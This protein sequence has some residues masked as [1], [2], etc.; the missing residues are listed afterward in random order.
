MPA[1]AAPLTR[2]KTKFD[3]V[4]RRS[5]AGLGLFANAPIPKGARIIEYTGRT[6]APGEDLKSR[7]KYLFAISEKKTIDGAPRD[8]LARYINHSC[9]PNCEPM[10]SRGRVF[11]HAKRAIKPGEELAYD[12]GPD[13]FTNYIEPHGCRCAKCKGARKSAGAN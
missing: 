5:A 9:R 8:N 12:Y 2:S 4:V 11:I 3:V 1:K 7:S 10:I 13:Y 6:L